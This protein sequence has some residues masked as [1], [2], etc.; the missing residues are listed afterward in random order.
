MTDHQEATTS[1]ISDEPSTDSGPDAD[2]V[3]E[4]GAEVEAI[5]HTTR[6][7]TKVGEGH[8]GGHGSPRTVGEAFAALTFAA[9]YCENCALRARCPEK[10]CAVWQA[11]TE[12]VNV[13]EREGAAIPVSAGV[14]LEPSAI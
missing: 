4:P 2:A 6:S 13:L 12:A 5:R 10:E 7:G 8:A 3:Q 1:S 9:G 14:P 11:E